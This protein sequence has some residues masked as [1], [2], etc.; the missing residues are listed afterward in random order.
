VRSDQKAIVEPI[1][2]AQRA[3]DAPLSVQIE[4]FARDTRPVFD[5]R[6]AMH[7]ADQ[8]GD[9]SAR[10]DAVLDDDRV[11]DTGKTAGSGNSF[12]IFDQRS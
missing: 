6:V 5:C 1:P 12:Q 2:S 9:R 11:I 8:A 10:E 4:K 3:S 7:L